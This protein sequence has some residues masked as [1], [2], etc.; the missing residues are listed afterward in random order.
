MKEGKCADEDGLTAEHFQNAPLFLFIRVTNLFNLMMRHSF[1]P[2]QFRL[3]FMT[4]IIKDNQ[5]N[6]GDVSN[7][8]GITI[9]PIIS[10]IFEHVLKLVFYNH[11][12][13][14][15]YQF[16]FKKKN[17]TAHALYCLKESVNYYIDNGSR[18]FCSFLDASK[19]FDRLVHLGLFIKLEPKNA[20]NLPRHRNHLA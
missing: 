7:Y 12:S 13:T 11:L 3:G 2:E 10:K 1:I 5:G 16:G 4:P 18:V 6:H 8:R 19:A 9:S 20:K 15:S 14:C 17:S